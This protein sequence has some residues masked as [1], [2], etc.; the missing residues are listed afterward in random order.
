M[1]QCMPR[2]N[3][4]QINFKANFCN[5]SSQ[6]LCN[7]LSCLYIIR[8]SG[9][10]RMKFDAQNSNIEVIADRSNSGHP[11]LFTNSK[12]A[13]LFSFELDR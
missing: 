13:G 10:I 9:L 6:S 1:A 8:F 4:R 3:T 11:G 5:L 2:K 12:M 7:V